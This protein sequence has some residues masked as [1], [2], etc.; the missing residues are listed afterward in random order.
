V[1]I[2]G[3]TAIGFV[4]APTLSS[5]TISSVAALGQRLAGGTPVLGWWDYGY[6]L[7][8]VGGVA[9]YQ[10]G[11][12]HGVETFLIARS[13]SSTAQDELY[14]TTAYLSNEGTAAL[15]AALD[16]AERPR[17]VLDD[18][19]R[20]SVPLQID[21]VHLIFIEAMIS[22]YAAIHYLGT[23]DFGRGRGVADGYQRI[24]CARW[25]NEKLHCD[26]MVIDTRTGYARADLSLERLTVIRDGQVLFENSYPQDTDVFLQ[27]LT[28]ERGAFD[29]YLLTQRVYESNFNQ[30]Y[31]LGRFDE[32][33]FELVHSDF[34][35][36]RLFRLR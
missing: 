31:F 36:M 2:S 33:R 4:P 29:F 20:Y 18:V 12:Y 8:A 16:E 13:F 21:G 5:R 7:Q 23:W 30:M 27:V 34:P 24:R 28:D 10:D 35:A 25:E 3:T 1:G 19:G 6:A 17:S 26:G 22:K 15:R 14:A 9:T 32:S 11:S